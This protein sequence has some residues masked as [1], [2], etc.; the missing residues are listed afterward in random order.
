MGVLV[1]QFGVS[2]T[3]FRYMYCIQVWILFLLL[4]YS[5]VLQGLVLAL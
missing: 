4:E 5:L 1:L 3:C 2:L